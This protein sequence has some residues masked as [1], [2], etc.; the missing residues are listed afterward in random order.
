MTMSAVKKPSILWDGKK[1]P[2]GLKRVP[3][4]RYVLEPAEAPPDLSLE[5]ERG[6]L[7]AIRQVRQGRTLTPAQVF[8]RIRDPKRPR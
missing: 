5:Q 7:N 3:P 6:L 2:S 1:L 4:G 8:A